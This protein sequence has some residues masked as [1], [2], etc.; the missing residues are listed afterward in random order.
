M[1]MPAS[2][3]TDLPCIPHLLKATQYK[4]IATSKGDLSNWIP[5]PDPTKNSY[6]ASVTLYVPQDPNLGSACTSAWACDPNKWGTNMRISG[7][8]AESGIQGC[9]TLPGEDGGIATAVYMQ[10]ANEVDPPEGFKFPDEHTRYFKVPVIVIAKDVGIPPASTAQSTKTAKGRAYE[11]PAWGDMD[12][13]RRLT[14]VEA[15][16]C[17]PSADS[18]G[19]QSPAQHSS[20]DTQV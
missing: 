1:N 8:N 18:Q 20:Q 13:D 2:L 9:F 12:K 3:H 15:D 7:V 14:D 17:A 10:G 6:E 16:E 4:G 5:Q 19:G 11:E